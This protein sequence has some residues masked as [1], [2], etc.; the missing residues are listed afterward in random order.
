MG[1]RTERSKRTYDRMA[2]EYDTSP[3]GNYTKAS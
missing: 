3:E 2:A 1:K